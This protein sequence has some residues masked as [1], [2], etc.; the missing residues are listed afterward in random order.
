PGVWP[1]GVLLVGYVRGQVVACELSESGRGALRVE[2]R[3]PGIHPTACDLHVLVRHPLLRKPCGFEGFG[4][5]EVLAASR[6]LPVSECAEFGVGHVSLNAAEVG[7]AADP[8][9]RNDV[10]ISGVDQFDRLDFE[11]VERVKPALPENPQGVLAAYW[12]LVI[13]SRAG[14]PQ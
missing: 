7:P 1:H 11:P 5:C 2:P 13:G 4:S 9:Y 3:D 10:V 14:P 12:A 6:D 8:H